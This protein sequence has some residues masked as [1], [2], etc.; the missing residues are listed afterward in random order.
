MR[1]NYL[2]IQ[3]LRGAAALLVVLHHAR[4]PYPWLFNPLE[5]FDGFARGVD[6][7]FVIS[8]F[9][10]AAIGSRESPIDFA[11]KRIVRVA[12]IYWLTTLAAAVLLFMKKGVDPDLTEHLM[13]SL[14]F[15]PHLNP[16]GEAF[17]VLPPGWTLNHEMYFYALFFL[18]LWTRHPV[19]N[20]CIAL[21]ACVAL[22]Q[23]TQP[24][25]IVSATYTHH[26]LTEFAAGL[27]MGRYRRQ[28]VSRPW[29]VWL[30]PVGGVL[31]F[32]TQ[33]WTMSTAGAA[34]IVMGA[35]AWER[36]I[37][38]A[39]WGQQLG[40]ASYF[41]YLSHYFVLGALLKIWA[42]LPLSGWLQFTSLLAA[43]VLTSMIVGLLGHKFIEKPLTSYLNN[44]FS[45]RNKLPAVSANP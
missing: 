17:P 20:C 36:K 3:Y 12:P 6:V 9:I 39:G 16:A 31:L 43:C 5:Q 33:H 35:L 19:R 23:I 2:S 42:R 25:G 29:L 10:M 8:G 15:I 45:T 41:T 24:T 38:I 1:E 27:L 11:R 13:K 37:G 34:F 18:C 40:N 44:W 26:L 21:L 4:N 14:L 32:G 22:G 30:A 28:I 7:F